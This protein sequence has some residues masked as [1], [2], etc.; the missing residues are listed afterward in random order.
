MDMLV[1]ETDEKKVR[2]RFDIQDRHAE[3]QMM[4]DSP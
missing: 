3:G 1:R 2:G 4:V